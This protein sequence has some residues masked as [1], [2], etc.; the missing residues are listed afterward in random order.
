MYYSD[1]GRSGSAGG[2]G[3]QLAYSGASSLR[4][5]Q[6]SR[7]INL[8]LSA[9]TPASFTTPFLARYIQTEPQVTPGRADATLTFNIN[10]Y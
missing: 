8:A 9:A 7:E 6:F 2:I 1:V 3:I 5:V 10:Y 4:M